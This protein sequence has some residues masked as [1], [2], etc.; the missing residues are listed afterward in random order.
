[1]INPNCTDYILEIPATTKFD[2]LAADLRLYINSMGCEWPVSPAI[3]THAVNGKMLIQP[4]LQVFLLQFQL[5]TLFNAYNLDW[6]VLFIRS[7]YKI[8]KIIKGKDSFGND[9]IDYD[10]EIT[11]AAD[12]NYLLPYIDDIIVSADINGNIVTRPMTMA[13]TIYLSMYAGTDVIIL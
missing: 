8:K 3:N 4:R 9:I 12:R 1:M 6:K 5:E 13:D 2:N 10:Y 7:A 11:K